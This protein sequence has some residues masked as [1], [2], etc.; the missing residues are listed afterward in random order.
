MKKY[1]RLNDKMGSIIRTDQIQSVTASIT[2][3]T[4]SI[5]SYSLIILYCSHD[6]CIH[7]QYKKLEDLA[8][9][10]NKMEAILIHGEE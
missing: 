6:S 7:Y 5:I 2:D 8:S 10:K 1:L 4:S 3:P 9:D